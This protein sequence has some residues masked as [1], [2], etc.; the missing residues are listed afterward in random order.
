MIV[1]T[2][3]LFAANAMILFVMAAVFAVTGFGRRNERYWRSWCVANILIGVALVGFL[4]ERHMPAYVGSL[5]PNLLLLVGFGLRWRAAREFSGRHAPAI[6]VWGPGI[7]FAALCLMTPFPANYGLVYTVVN[8]VLAVQACAVAAEFWRDRSDGLPSRYA[9][10]VSY[11]LMSA[12]FCVR[13]GQGLIEGHAMNA[14]LPHDVLLM[15]H[16]IV[17]TVHTVSAGGFALSLAHERIAAGLLQAATHDFLTGTRN[18]GA[19]EDALRQYLTEDGRRFALLVVDLDFFKRINDRHGHAAGDAALRTCASLFDG[20]LGAGDCV[21]RL[22]GEEF[23]ILMTDIDPADA[24]VSAER[25]RLS[26]AQSVME[27]EGRRFHL[28]VSGGLCCGV[29]G[30][31]DFDTLMSRADAALYAAKNGGRNRIVLAEDVS[32]IEERSGTRGR[33]VTGSPEPIVLMQGGK[34]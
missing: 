20:S 24:Y 26:I 30:A 2:F 19:F 31:V 14:Y 12:S 15:L 27:F 8:M 1:D 17:A 10:V 25:M 3:S 22:G 9:L 7:A 33:P 13:I 16:L 18:R 34:A 11:G 28:T 21:G 4:Y 29:S 6:V 23:A 32:D 5:T